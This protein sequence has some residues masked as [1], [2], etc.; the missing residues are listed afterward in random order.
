VVEHLPYTQAVERFDSLP[1]YSQIHFMNIYLD[2]AATTPIDPEIAKVMSLCLKN[3]FGNPSS[4]HKVGR[5]AK[6]ALNEAREIILKKINPSNNGQLV[7]T[8]GGTEANNMILS[9]IITKEKNHIIST[10]IEHDCILN[11]LKNLK[12]SGQI[13]YD[14]LKVNKEGFVDPKELARKINDQTALVSII[15]GHN[16]IGTIQPLEE[17]AKICQE[18]NIPLHIDAC[19]SFGKVP[20]P[21]NLIDAIT[22]NSHKLH[23]PKGVGALYLKNNLKLEPLIFGGGQESSLRSGTENVTGILGFAK[24]VEKMSAIESVKVQRDKLQELLLKIPGSKINGSTNNNCRLPNILNMSFT[25]IDGG[26]LLRSLDKQGVYLSTGSA[27]SANKNEQS[28]VLK[29]LGLSEDEIRGSIRISL[30]RMNTEE[31]IDRAGKIISE[32]IEKLKGN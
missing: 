11:T 6:R 21:I 8:S 28:H 30:S 3:N 17:I 22:I 20:I 27:C 29:A 12:K 4:L 31:E 16:E 25:G 24:A 15:Y 9:G 18:K 10:E 13:T 19:Q 5:E 26:I 2:N 7:F 23:G 14:L 1:L 32:T